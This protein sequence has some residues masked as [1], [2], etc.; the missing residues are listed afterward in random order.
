MY[1]ATVSPEAVCM[2]THATSYAAGV[3]A[4]SAVGC[5]ELL[6]TELH[7]HPAM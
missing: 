3:K 2:G 1:G 5:L 7:Y 6:P 4:S